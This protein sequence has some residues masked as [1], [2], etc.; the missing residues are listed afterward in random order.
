LKQ[1]A[2]AKT[3]RFAWRRTVAPKGTAL[4]RVLNKNPDVVSWWF[5]EGKRTR[6]EDE[7]FAVKF[8]K[9][10]EELSASLTQSRRSDR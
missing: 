7:K 2:G 9:L 1:I 8:D 6:L 5:G 3:G 4:A 10:D